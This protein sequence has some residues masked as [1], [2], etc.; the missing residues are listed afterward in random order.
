MARTILLAGG[1]G[2][3]GKMVLELALAD[4]RIERVIAL[5]RRPLPDHPKLEQ[6]VGADLE[7]ALK[8]KRPDSVICCLGTTM[9]NVGGDKSAFIR[10]DQELVLALGRWASGPA[11][12]FCV[13]SSFGAHERSMFFYN[14]V[15]GI[16]EVGLRGMDFEALEIFRP[17]I[18]D[19]PRSESRS[20][21]RIGLGLMKLIAPVLPSSYRPMSHRVLAQ[22]LVNAAVGSD[23]GVHVN[24]YTRIRELAR[25]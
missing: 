15:K 8:E 25:S 23:L 18:L 1:T 20:G 16:M 5:V 17:S 22:A 3:V 6:W 4:P 7:K 10:V 19:G 12:R 11:V 14:R 9:R 21:E 2:L 24:T 13:V